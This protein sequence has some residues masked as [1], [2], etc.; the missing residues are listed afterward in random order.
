[1]GQMAVQAIQF[2][3]RPPRPIPVTRHPAMN[4]ALVIAHLCAMT[5]S[6][7]L[8]YLL[9]RNRGPIRQAEAVVVI[10]IMT[11]ETTDTA[12]GNVPVGMKLPQVSRD[13]IL[14][15]G[16]SIRV[17]SRA[18]N[19]DWVALKVELSGRNFK[20]ARRRFD[21]NRERSRLAN[22][23]RVVRSFRFKIIASPPRAGQQ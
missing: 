3:L 17:A 19:F 10:R 5:L 6:T 21:C 7:Q 23:G 4:A 2:E 16:L 14:E 20:T 9:M 22:S 1:M 18:S 8:H 12:M 15:I 13:P 11:G